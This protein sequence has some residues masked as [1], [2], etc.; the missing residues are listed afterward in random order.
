M[1]LSVCGLI[2]NECEFYNIT[3]TGCFNVKGSPSWALEMMPEKICPLYNCSVNQK[4]FRNCGDCQDLPCK[5]FR[6]MKDPSLSDRE[7]QISLRKR[8]AALRS[9]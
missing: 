1:S 5:L 4:G 7:H 6:E 3:C 9:N 2:C 8:V